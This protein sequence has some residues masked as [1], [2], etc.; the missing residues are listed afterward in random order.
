MSTIVNTIR[1]CRLSLEVSG[2]LVLFGE[3]AEPRDGSRG[4]P[5]CCSSIVGLR[6]PDRCWQTR[7]LETRSGM[8]EDKSTA[9]VPLTEDKVHAELDDRHLPGRKSARMHGA[10]NRRSDRTRSGELVAQ[11]DDCWPSAGAWAVFSIVR[12]LEAV[13]LPGRILEQS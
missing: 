10:D 5:F 11:R 9:D 6:T 1:G 3:C 2:R 7:S 8:T 4:T 13:G 12:A